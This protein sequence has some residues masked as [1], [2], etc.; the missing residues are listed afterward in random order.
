MA[1]YLSI[2]NQTWLCLVN[3]TL[4]SV[5]QPMINHVCKYHLVRMGGG[6]QS[7]FGFLSKSG[8]FQNEK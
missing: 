7:Y 8:L 3:T 1:I 5:L 4:C 2:T 6:D